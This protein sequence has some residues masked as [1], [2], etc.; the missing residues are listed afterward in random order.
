MRNLTDH[1]ERELRLAGLYDEDSD[2]GGLLAYG[3]VRLI[4]TFAEE[5]HS[6]FSAMQSIRIFNRLAQF[7]TLTP[8]TDDPGEWQN[9]GEVYG[10][11][12]KG[13]WQSRR[14][15]SCFSNDGGETYYDL[16]EKKPW[17]LRALS[18]CHLLR[19]YRIM[20]VSQPAKTFEEGEEGGSK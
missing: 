5:G 8:L 12:G 11:T 4:R 20:H 6:G 9:C 17:W 1:A 7:K 19:K 14:Q 3:A 15:S 2:Y 10:P 18:R 13:V 16:D